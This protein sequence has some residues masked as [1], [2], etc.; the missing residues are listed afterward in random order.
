MP[1]LT[2]QTKLAAAQACLASSQGSN[3]QV[4][5]FFPVKTS[6]QLPLI[7]L[8]MINVLSSHLQLRNSHVRPRGYKTFFILNSVEHEIVNVHKYKNIMKFGHF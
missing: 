3:T 8:S 5:L 6:I 2:V 4:A 7:R 1:E